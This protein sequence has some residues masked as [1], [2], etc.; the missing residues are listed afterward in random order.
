[1]IGWFIIGV[2]MGVILAV[3]S[4]VICLVLLAKRSNRWGRRH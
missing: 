3:G 4:G 1:M 2:I